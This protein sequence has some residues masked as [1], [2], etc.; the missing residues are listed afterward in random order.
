MDPARN[1]A[2]KDLLYNMYGKEGLSTV[3]RYVTWNGG[4]TTTN[5]QKW[6]SIFVCP[7]TRALYLSRPYGANSGHAQDGVIWFSTLKSAEHGAA[8]N[9]HDFREYLVEAMPPTLLLYEG[10]LPFEVG[11][12]PDGIPGDKQIKVLELQT[13]DSAD[14]TAL[15]N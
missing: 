14:T 6:T 10:E 4:A 9:A 12:V 11:R 7:K 5:A 3:D 15:P 1:L 2:P 13:T 8:A